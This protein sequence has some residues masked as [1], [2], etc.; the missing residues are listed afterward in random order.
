[1]GGGRSEGEAGVEEEEEDVRGGA[2]VWSSRVCQ[3]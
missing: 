2:F 1:M 3:L